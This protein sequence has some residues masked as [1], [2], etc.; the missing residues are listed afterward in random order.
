MMTVDP[1]AEFLMK[2]K[3]EEHSAMPHHTTPHISRHRATKQ[4]TKSFFL[5]TLFVFLNFPIVI[6]KNV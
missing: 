2:P 1:H 5:R 6:N 3:N 4:S